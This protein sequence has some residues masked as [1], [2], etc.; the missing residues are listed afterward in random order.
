MQD[1]CSLCGFFEW[2][3]VT[4][5]PSLHRENE[6]GSRPPPLYLL[7]KHTRTYIFVTVTTLSKWELTSLWLWPHYQSCLKLAKGFECDGE[8]G[9]EGRGEEL[10]N[11]RLCPPR[12]CA[13]Q[14]SNQRAPGW[15]CDHARRALKVRAVTQGKGDFPGWLLCVLATW[16]I[17][18]ASWCQWISQTGPG[19]SLPLPIAISS[20]LG[21]LSKKWQMARRLLSLQGWQGEK[22]HCGTQDT[23]VIPGSTSNSR[24]TS[25]FWGGVKALSRLSAQGSIM[26]EG[27]CPYT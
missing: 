27:F 14:M 19:A 9:K 6:E 13:F 18:Q 11:C 5:W 4:Q 16:A 2:G 10:H 26:L 8:V 24:L 12:T 22:S 7:K 1:T 21:S 25:C 20:S 15:E 17:H 23:S 3:D